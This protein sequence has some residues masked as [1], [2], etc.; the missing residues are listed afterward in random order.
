MFAA[1]RARLGGT[2]SPRVDPAF[3]KD[4]PA[5]LRADSSGLEAGRSSRR[6]SGFLP[7]RDH[8][9][10]L[11]AQS[12]QTT[13]A[14]ARFLVRNNGYAAN[15]IEVF[16]GAAVGAGIVPS[17]KIT[18]AAIRE[19]GNKLWKRWTDEADAEGLTDF[20]GL[21]RRAARELFIAGE[22]F[23]R[24]RYR[25]MSDGLSVPLQLQMLPSEMLDVNYTVPWTNGTTIRQGIEFDRIGRRVAYHFW[26]RHPGDST[27]PNILGDRVRVPADQVLHIVDPVEA[28]QLRGLTKFTAAIVKLWSLDGY[29]DAEL[30]RKKTAALLGVF[31]TRE[32]PTGDLFDEAAEEAAAE[33][34]G[35][36]SVTLEPGT[37]HNLLPGEEPKPVM[38]AD[39]GNSYE[40]F[41][42]RTLLQVAVAL[43]IPYYT[44]TGDL[45][46]ASYGS[47]RGGML[48]FKRR[49]EAIQHS[50]LVFLMCRPVRKAWT[51][52][53]VLSGALKLKGYA[54]DPSPWLDVDHIPPVFDWIDPLKDIQAAIIAK[55]AGLTSRTAIIKG[56]GQDPEAVDADIK[57]DKDREERLG[58]SFSSET[59]VPK[60]IEDKPE[61]AAPPAKQD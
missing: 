51:D 4:A 11:I 21:Q 36:G 54:D 7:G 14:R 33:D 39:S 44:L 20:Y 23:V 18:D 19:A 52:Q 49:M 1:L 53:A 32:D 25:K 9:N 56:Q 8:V 37:V 40:P 61:P 17:W 12:G 50:V 43:G 35:I 13:L 59:T 5:K 60:V 2:P 3:G 46:G 31:I 15:G 42:Y 55:N 27:D 29:D 26:R 38:P 30:E 45:R 48:E 6:M 28:G 47:Q 58:L 57:A 24:L 16:A 41:Q 10:S 34:G 22:V